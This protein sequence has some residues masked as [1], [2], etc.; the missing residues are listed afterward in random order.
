[1]SKPRDR[2]A[3]K[4]PRTKHRVQLEKNVIGKKLD[5]EWVLLNLG[6]GVYYGLNETGSLIWDA[7]KSRQDTEAVIDRLQQDFQV[8]RA[9]IRSDLKNFLDQLEREGLVK[10]APDSA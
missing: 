5:E 3:L 2:F 7:L 4:T 6:N 8:E 10:V 9:T 1:M